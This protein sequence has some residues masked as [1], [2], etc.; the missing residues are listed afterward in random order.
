MHTSFFHLAYIYLAVQ[1]SSLF[2]FL[3]QFLREWNQYH[4][5]LLNEWLKLWQ[6][7]EE[8]ANQTTDGETELEVSNK[9]PLW[10]QSVLHS[11]DPIFP[12]KFI[13]FFQAG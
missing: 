10:Y 2:F 11:C 9:G 4:D 5:G 7:T 12:T 1:L 3:L 6:I 8:Q 13:F